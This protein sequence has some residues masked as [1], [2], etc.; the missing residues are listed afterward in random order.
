VQ[1][2]P[3]SERGRDLYGTPPQAVEALLRCEQIPQHVWECATGR[4]AI[5]KVLREHGRQVICSD[6]ETYDYPLDFVADFLATTEMPAGAQ[7]IL[8]NPPFQVAERFVE[9][10]LKLSPLVIMLARLAFF[11]SERRRHI[12]ENCGLARIH[13]F[14]RRLP[15][16][17]RDQWQGRKAN[18]GMAFAWFIWDRNYV[19]PTN[20]SRISWER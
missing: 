11:E 15:M 2:H 14:R 16:M 13:C 19:G 10:A 5:A 1:R 12:L 6:I 17:H 3:L 8:T 18:S 20:I 4:G 9:H 7:I